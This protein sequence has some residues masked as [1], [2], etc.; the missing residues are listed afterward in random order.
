MNLVT[1]LQ[2]YGVF[3]YAIVIF[4]GG[5]WGLK[6]FTYYRKTKYNFLVFAT[7]FALLFIFLELLAGR[8]DMT[9]AVNYLL[10]Y[11]VVTSCYEF[12]ADVFPFIKPK[13]DEKPG[14]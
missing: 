10:T 8:F 14:N 3:I 13:Q 4:F 11:T 2:Q 1:I 12:F 6:Y 9:Q 5:R 7:V